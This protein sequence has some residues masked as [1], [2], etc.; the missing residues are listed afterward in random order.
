MAL[1][2]GEDGRGYELARRLESCGAW[3]AWLGD[4]AYAAFAHSLS[5]A[6]AWD[7]FM[8]SSSGSRAQL[9]LKLRAR[10][11]LF[12]KASASL[13]LRPS[14]AMVA[15]H[16]SN[17]NPSYLQLHEDEIYCSLEDE[18][19]DGF[20]PQT[21]SR[22]AYSPH[23]ASQHSFE[24]ASSVGSKY[25]DHEHLNTSKYEDLLDK[26][27]IPY[28][29]RYRMKNL[30]F[31]FGEKE[32]HKRTP[33]GM[34]LYSR[35]RDIHKRKR[36]IF[37]DHPL[38]TLDT[39][40]SIHS[41]G[42]SER[43]KPTEEVISFFPEIMFP[44][45]CVPESALPLLI[46][47]KKLKVEVYGALD[48]LPTVISPS[49]AMMERFG[50][51]PEYIKM[52]NKYRGKGGSEGD[53]SPLSQEQASQMAHKAVAR[54]FTSVGFEGGTEVSMK[55]FSDFFSSHISKLGRNLK[56]LTDNYKKQVSSIEL[57]KMFLQISG[58]GNLGTLAEI[59]KN[60]SKVGF[61]H[62]TQQIVRQL[63]SPQQNPLLQ[64]QQFQ[65]QMHPQ[66][67]LLHPQNIAFQQQQQQQLQQ[68]QQWD[69]LRR[70]QVS[71]R[72]SVMIIDKDQPLTDVKIENIVEGPIDTNSFNALNKQQMH[73]RQ[74]QMAMAN[75][76]TQ[77]GQHFKQLQSIQIPQLQAQLAQNTFNMRNVPV[78][79][80][81]FQELMS[82]DSTLKLEPDQNKL[83]PPT[84]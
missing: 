46:T 59:T 47:E 52:G 3:R 6:A 84:K 5:S 63:P 56:L 70:R 73:L 20:Q 10:A 69:K 57:L 45:N 7:A 14:T 25:N 49:P 43:T 74:Q 22:P 15:T 31:P 16:I 1:L 77:S 76:P 55:I 34:S 67:N 4:A 23:R 28:A 19:H 9:L 33:E 37:K 48:N 51:R 78:K 54:L 24:L 41:E 60:S 79:V 38:P 80:E 12:D 66:M 62:Q 26:C 83:N 35:L 81:A 72:G 75:H 30:K 53:K 44:A 29:E 40:S 61:T 32:S 50:I 17:L 27:Y 13:F 8:S 65:R 64:A 2:L 21:P 11:L 36:Q 68:Q 71:G 58:H 82:G 18:Q 39:G 42:I